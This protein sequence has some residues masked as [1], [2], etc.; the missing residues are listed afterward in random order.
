MGDG[1]MAN[2]FSPFTTVIIRPCTDCKR[3]C[4]ILVGSRVLK[5]EVVSVRCPDCLVEFRK[6][7][8]LSPEMEEEARILQLL[9]TRQESMKPGDGE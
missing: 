3:D 7:G 5:G 8:K 9:I 4:A 2:P 6:K 1:I